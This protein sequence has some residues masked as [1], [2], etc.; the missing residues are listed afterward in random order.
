M[1]RRF[2]FTTRCTKITD[3]AFSSTVKASELKNS[4][5]TKTTQPTSAAVGQ[6]VGELLDDGGRLARHQP[7]EIAADRAEQL[8]FAHHVRERDHRQD[9]Q[10][11]DRQQGVVGHRAGEQQALVGTKGLEGLPGEST[12]MTQHV[13]CCRIDQPLAQVALQGA[14]APLVSRLASI[15]GWHRPHSAGRSNARDRQARCR[16]DAPCRHAANGFADRLRSRS[17]HMS[18]ACAPFVV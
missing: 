14:R 3:I 8:A 12:G 15:G 6:K 17:V 16:A 13:Q 7:G 1:K 18:R 10:G 4:M 9:E 5:A 11:H 2:F